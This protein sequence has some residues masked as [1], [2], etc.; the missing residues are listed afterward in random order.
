MYNPEKPATHGTQDEENTKQKH[1]TI[2]VG[3]HKK[4]YKD[5]QHQKPGVNSDKVICNVLCR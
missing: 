5:E 2:L 3:Q 1:N 4:T